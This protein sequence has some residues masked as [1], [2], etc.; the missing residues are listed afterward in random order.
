LTLEITLQNKNPKTRVLENLPK[1]TQM[2][3]EAWGMMQ[4]A[5]KCPNPKEY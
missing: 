3:S 5:P 1:L 2:L 4:K